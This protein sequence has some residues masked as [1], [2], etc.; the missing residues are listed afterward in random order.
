MDGFV[1][2]LRVQMARLGVFQQLMMS[3][4]LTTEA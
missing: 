2:N 3:L 4:W 1:R